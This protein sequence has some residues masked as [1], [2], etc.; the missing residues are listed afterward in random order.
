M[1]QWKLDKLLDAIA[2]NVPHWLFYYNH[3]VLAMTDNPEWHPRAEPG[4]SLRL[5]RL[6]DI[7]LLAKDGYTDEKIASRLDVG[8]RGVVMERDNEVLSIIWGG[9]GRKFLQL[10]GSIFDTGEDGFFLYGGYTIEKARLRGL[11]YNV[12]K[13]IY[14]LY[15]VEG[16]KRVW[17]AISASN[18]EWRDKFFTRMNFQRMGE[19]YYMRFLFFN[20]CYYKSWPQPVKKFYIFLKNPPENLECV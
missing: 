17:C 18:T 15:S 11:F 8:D 13:H 12:C 2:W 6:E 19:T 5:V 10:S 20:V 16:Y 1:K 3:S 9:R 7:S 14:D 4:C